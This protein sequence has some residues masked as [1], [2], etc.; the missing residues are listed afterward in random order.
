MSKSNYLTENIFMLLE[1][2]KLHCHYRLF[3]LHEYSYHL[4]KQVDPWYTICIYSHFYNSHISNGM[5]NVINLLLGRVIPSFP[6]DF[7]CTM[8]DKHKLWILAHLS[9]LLLGEFQRRISTPSQRKSVSVW[10]LCTTWAHQIS[11][12]IWTFL[13]A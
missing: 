8:L 12:Q 5:I 13:Y 4:E 9:F 1:G 11:V 2:K 10:N 6:R 7:L 3:V